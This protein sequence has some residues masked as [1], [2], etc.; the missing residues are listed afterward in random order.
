ME[1]A[2]ASPA[3]GVPAKGIE[4]LESE[5]QVDSVPVGGEVPAWLTGSLLRTG[6]AKWEVGE[7]SMNHLRP[8]IGRAS[9]R[10]RV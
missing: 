9:C 3:T 2:T 7:R 10:E 4:S 1:S 5:T 8:E 6:P